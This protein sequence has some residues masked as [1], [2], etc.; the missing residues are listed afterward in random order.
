MMG[1]RENIRAHSRM[2]D[3]RFLGFFEVLEHNLRTT[4]DR[5]LPMLPMLSSL[6]LLGP[7]DPSL[8][9]TWKVHAGK[10]SNT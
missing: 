10:P 6:Q 1:S 4:M 7:S 5:E 2:Y 3:Y 8:F 9:H